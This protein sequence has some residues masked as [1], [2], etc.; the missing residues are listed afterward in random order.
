MWRVLTDANTNHASQFLIQ[1]PINDP[2]CGTSSYMAA[3]LWLKLSKTIILALFCIY[4]WLFDVSID[5]HHQIL[6]LLMNTFPQAGE[7]CIYGLSR[8]WTINKALILLVILWTKTDLERAGPG[9]NANPGTCAPGISP[10]PICKLK[11]CGI[12]FIKF[13]WI[14]RKA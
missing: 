14:T 11:F 8:I 12:V 5:H 1:Y 9:S 2:C 4:M 3:F 10:P 7:N 13:D 6:Q